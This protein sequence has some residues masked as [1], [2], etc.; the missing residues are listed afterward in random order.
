MEILRLMPQNDIMT[1]SPRGER[2][3][4][5]GLTFRKRS[6]QI[7][8]LSPTRE[9]FTRL[10]RR[11]RRPGVRVRGQPQSI[12]ESILSK[13]RGD[14]PVAPTYQILFSLNGLTQFLSCRTVR[15][16]NAL[17]ITAIPLIKGGF[18]IDIAQ[19][20]FYSANVVTCKSETRSLHFP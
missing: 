9:R 11:R 12:F 16:C 1:Q 18:I 10:W 4:W 5:F 17:I 19:P 2:V 20:F 7:I 13:C 8:S 3:N 14:R 6:K 15:S